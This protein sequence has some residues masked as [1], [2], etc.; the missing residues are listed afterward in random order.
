MSPKVSVT[1]WLMQISWCLKVPWPQ[2]QQVAPC[3]LSCLAM[4]NHVRAEGK[5]ELGIGFNAPHLVTHAPPHLSVYPSLGWPWTCSDLPR[6]CES[7]PG[8]LIE[9]QVRA[10][11]NT[12]PEWEKSQAITSVQTLE[13]NIHLGLFHLQHVKQHSGWWRAGRTLPAILA[14][15]LGFIKIQMADKIPTP[16]KCMLVFFYFKDNLER[17]DFKKWAYSCF[18]SNSRPACWQLACHGDFSILK[19]S[20]ITK[21]KLSSSQ[22]VNCTMQYRLW[23]LHERL[24]EPPCYDTTF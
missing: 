3:L 6:H 21:M 16:M 7:E 22:E 11:P 20:V 1:V 5:R 17:K 10:W 24:I 8:A 2:V 9:K 19:C 15:M 4:T 14:K 18:P 13:L 12:R 23:W